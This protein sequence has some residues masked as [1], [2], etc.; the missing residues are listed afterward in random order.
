M[1]IL[2]TDEA[3]F[4]KEGCFNAHNSHLWSDENPHAIRVCDTQVRWSVNVWAGICGTQIIGPY[5]LPDR[6]DGGAYKAFLQHVLPDLLEDVPLEVRRNMYY[7]HDG[8]PAHYDAQ[9]RA[10]LTETFQ[11]R[12]IGR[13]GPVAWPP[14]SPDIN[15]LDFFFW[16]YLKN[17]VYR[18]PVQTPEELVAKIHAAVANISTETLEKV[19]NNMVRRLRAL[20][21][22]EGGQF[23]HLL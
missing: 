11:D 20:Q 14:R 10:Y 22:A 1:E 5:L 8:A 17:A 19:H 3:L 23:E 6:L 9:V 21:E 4:T 18:Q 13:G 7:Q 16:G 2:W 15:P 12:W